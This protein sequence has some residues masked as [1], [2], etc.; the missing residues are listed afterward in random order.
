MQKATAFQMPMAV[1]TAK[2]YTAFTQLPLQLKSLF[3][4]WVP[5]PTFLGLEPL[6]LMFPPYDRQAWL[7]GDKRTAS[8][9]TSIDIIV[10]QDLQTLAP[11]A[12]NFL[13]NW[14]ISIRDVDKMLLDQ[15]RTGDDSA[16]VACRWVQNHESI[17]TDWLPDDAETTCSAQF[18]L[19]NE[20]TYEFVE[21]RTDK[22]GLTCR[23]CPSGTCLG[24][25]SRLNIIMFDSLTVIMYC[26]VFFA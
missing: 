8:T 15:I 13:E 4:W 12:K 3:Y 2:D 22:S 24:E 25:P 10:S 9:T 14:D 26:T 20:M 21:D 11:N 19:Y 5:D 23:A 1:T 7:A 17:W 18:G 6:E 16:T